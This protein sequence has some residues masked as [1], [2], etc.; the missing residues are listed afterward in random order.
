MPVNRF[1][2]NYVATEAYFS[3]AGVHTCIFSSVSLSSVNR[4]L[5]NYVATEAYF[6]QAG[7]HTGFVEYRRCVILLVLD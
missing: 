7:V 3:Q 2:F 6:S 5:F 4:F 1:L